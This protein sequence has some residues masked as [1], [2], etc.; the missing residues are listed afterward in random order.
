MVDVVELVEFSLVGHARGRKFALVTVNK[1]CDRVIKPV[2][3]VVLEVFI[4]EM[5]WIKLS[6][7][8]KEDATRVAEE[9]W[10]IDS[11][12]VIFKF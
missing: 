7:K 6:F 12:S 10:S 9:V 11:T 3:S 5:G 4:L 8:S 1:W 2:M